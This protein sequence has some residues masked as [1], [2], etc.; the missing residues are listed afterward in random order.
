MKCIY[1]VEM[2]YGNPSVRALKAAWSSFEVAKAIAKAHARVEGRTFLVWEM[3][4]DTHIAAYCKV[5]YR[6]TDK[7]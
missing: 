6:S 2:N 3:S 7:E 5:V 1:V 4:L